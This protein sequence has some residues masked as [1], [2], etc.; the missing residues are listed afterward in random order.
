MKQITERLQPQLQQIN[1]R[2]QGLQQREQRLL[3]GLAG[4]LLFTFLWLGVWKPL[5]EGVA[6]A[7]QQ[8]QSQQN[9]QAWFERQAA[10]IYQQQNANN[11]RHSQ[12][13][14]QSHELSA[15]LNRATA[16]LELNIT[17]IQPQN[18]AQVVVF[19]EA[20]FTK[21]LTLI[22]RLVARG[23]TIESLDVSETNTPGVVRVRR[24]QV[25]VNA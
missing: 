4:L 8:L 9:Y 16:E 25:K 23:V 5:H 10:L 3:L 21:L 14:I 22:E 1:A 6:R 24:L 12:Q 19:D 13:P 17:R 18:E 11:S 15:F 20:S 2:W 7:E